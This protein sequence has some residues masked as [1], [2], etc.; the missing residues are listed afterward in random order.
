MRHELRRS[1]VNL[2]PRQRVAED[3][4]VSEGALDA[5]SGAE[6]GEPPLQAGDLAQPLDVAPRQRQLAE[7]R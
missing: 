6:I 5:L 3:A 7:A 4:A 1:A 2:E